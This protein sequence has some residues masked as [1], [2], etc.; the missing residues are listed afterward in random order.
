MALDAFVAVPE[1]TIDEDGEPVARQD[2]VGLA[3][4]VLPMEAESET[5]RMQRSPDAHFDF[6]ILASDSRHVSTA[7]RGIKSAVGHEPSVGR[8][9]AAGR[10]RHTAGMGRWKTALCWRSYWP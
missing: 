8:R 10:L 1:A 3:R 6:G 7:R 5:C 4:Q 2:D 9:S